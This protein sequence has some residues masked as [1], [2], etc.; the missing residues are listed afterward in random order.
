M[1]KITNLKQ[2]VQA[3]KDVAAQASGQLEEVAGAAGKGAFSISAGPNGVSIS[4]NF[5]ELIKKKTSGNRIASPIK[6]LY[7]ND[8]NKESLIYPP[9][10][11]N[12]H[13]MVFKVMKERR[14]RRTDKREI[15]TYQNIVLPIP[16]NLQ[17]QYSANYSDASLGAFGA[18]AAGKVNAA[19]ISNAASSIGDMISNKIAAATNTFKTQDT[20]AA[21]KGAGMIGPAVAT[22]V[23]T[24]IAGPLGGLLAL[25]GTSGGVVAGVSVS[26]GLALNPHL[27]VVFEGVG[28]RTHQFTYKFMARDGMESDTI[29]RIINTFQYYM[30]PSYA[31]GSMAFRYPEEFEIEFA[32][33]I[34]PYLYDIG[35]CVL[36]DVSVNY[37][38]E[39]IPLFFENTG[40]PV[41]I[42]M[43]MT[44]QETHILTKERLKDRV[45]D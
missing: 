2:V 23:A 26:E 19:D 20:D 8:K 17:V 41:S 5:N 10:L 14:L 24:K 18:M 27:A 45:E 37:N 3:G 38:G 22:G 13:F 31:V 35:T 1:P 16:S 32:D 39:G 7:Q 28:F 43:S 33:S 21:T 29:K 4:A 11:D 9:D 36:K 34:S 15:S 44:F 40:A 42:E 12:E 6:E 30:H 25:G